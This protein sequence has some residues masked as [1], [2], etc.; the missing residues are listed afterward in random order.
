MAKRKTKKNLLARRIK[1]LIGAAVLFFILSIAAY[2]GAV[3]AGSQLVDEQKL[4]MVEASTI[5][6]EN[7][8]EAG[9]LFIENREYVTLDQVPDKLEKAFISVEDARFYDHGGID[10]IAIG[11]ALYV[12]ILA[13]EAIQGGSTITQQLARNAFLS[14]EKK[15]LRKTKEALI[16]VYLDRKY[17][18]DQILEMYLNQIYF[19]HGA[20][21]VEAAAQLY[22]GKSVN[23]LTVSQMAML[24]ALPKGPNAYSPFNNP[25]KALE[26]RNLVLRLM[27]EHQVI[28]PEERQEAEKQELNLAPEPGGQKAYLR[29]YIDYVIQE[30]R[31]KYDISEDDLYRGGYQIYTYLNLDAQQRMDQVFKNDQLFP[32]AGKEREV[33]SGMVIVNPKNGGITALA[34]GRHYVAKGLNHAIRTRQP[35]STFKPI[36]VYAPA[37]EKGWHPY[38]MLKDEKMNFG[39]Y[40]PR[41][42][43][44]KYRGEVTMIEA[45]QESYNVPAVWLLNEIGVKAGVQSAEKFGI[46]LADQDHNLA[47]ALGGL[48]HGVSPLQMAQAYSAFANNGI[49]IEAHAIKK[50]VARDGTV[51]GEADP[52]S[53]VVISEQTAYYM[54]R[55]L[56]KVVQEGTGRNARMAWPVAGKTGTTQYDEVDNGNKDAWF[57][58]Y[59]PYYVG[60]VWL[61]FGTTDKDHY[62]TGG[63]GYA[64]GIFREVMTGVHQGLAVHPFQKPDGV[65]EL[66]P[67]VQL[68]RIE[69]LSAELAL[70]TELKVHLVW[71][72]NE[73]ERITYRIYRF[74]KDIENRELVD[75]V[76]GNNWVGPF[77][78]DKMY[79]YVVVPVNPFTGEEGELS[80]V[81]EV[82]WTLLP[83]ILQFGEGH[84]QDGDD[85]RGENTEQDR[86]QDDDDKKRQERIE[87][88]IREYEERDEPLPDWLIDL[89]E[90][91][92]GQEEENVGN[93]QNDSSADEDPQPEEEVTTQ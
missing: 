24:A 63:S 77:D 42:Y 69:D 10:F 15:I 22:F 41:N 57:V 18:K 47:I 92:E 11:R 23:E 31:E 40:Q 80:N 87:E 59:T 62:L 2:W 34:G 53:T 90:G 61:G 39:N 33:E 44:G 19:G 50:I 82:N 32:P 89:I 21:G 67:P 1:W 55:M 84:E 74:T 75:E 64:A 8:N 27:E 83:S 35:G 37:L 7:G 3:Y 85:S 65:E 46:P 38:D 28:T 51:I 73:D 9:K 26:R 30:A 52:Q 6:D 16:A 13:G 56:E 36:A 48:T 70:D 71:T 20:Y 54:T 45:L 25:E 76:S 72:P 79:K 17:S 78:L 14:H 4:K 88:L 86:D 91:E 81:A 43:D 12:D 49:M 68:T 93:G 66:R 60:A 29:A 58:G 5:L